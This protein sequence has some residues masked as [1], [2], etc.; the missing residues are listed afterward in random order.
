MSYSRL[1]GDAFE[2]IVRSRPGFQARTFWN[3]DC[4]ACGDR[5]KRCGFARTASG[6][7]R[8]YCQNGGCTY[9]DKPTG[10]EPG[11]P[12]IGR[13][14]ELFKKFGGDLRVFSPEDIQGDPNRIRAVSKAR[15][16]IVY[17]KFK[18]RELPRG[19]ILLVEAIEKDQRSHAVGNWLVNQRSEVYLYPEYQKFFFWN[20]LEPNVLRI[21]FWHNDSIIGHLDRNIL[22][23][24]YSRFRQSSPEPYLFNQHIVAGLPGDYVLVVESPMDAILLNGV[25]TRGSKP[26]LY[27]INFLKQC[28]KTPIMVPDFQ[29]QEGLK[30]LEIAKDNK[31]PISIPDWPYKD[32]GEAFNP[33]GVLR[34]IDLILQSRS[35]IYDVAE[36]KIRTGKRSGFNGV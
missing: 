21:A 8:I 9:H 17:T 6:G 29:K 16:E 32:P 31:W 13:A 36:M 15:E 12:F 18:E 22:K 24:D 33:L 27:Q 20:G 34:T 14:A 35:N 26:N 3:V 11:S 7:F 10:W 25:A 19:S 1:V 2:R 30:F 23:T 28:G 5:R 4:P